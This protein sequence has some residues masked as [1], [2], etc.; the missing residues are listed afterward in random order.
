MNILHITPAMDPKM[1]GVCQ[2]VRTMIVGLHEFG[3]DNEVTSL[4]S[5]AA[6]F[7]N[8]DS[9]LIHP[10]GPATGPWL[11]S[12]T[13]YKWLISNMTRFDIV[14]VHGLWSYY[15]Y[16][17]IKAFQHIKARIAVSYK[18]EDS[19]PKLFVM[20]HGMLD[21]YFQKAKGR[22]IKSFRNWIYWKLLEKLL[23]NESNG[24]L[25]TC[26]E[27]RRLARKS[28]KPYYPR[29]ELVVGLGVEEPPA[30]TTD[31]H[32]A[33]LEKCPEAASSK[34]ILFLGRIDEKKGVDILITAYSKLKSALIPLPHLVI[35]GPGLSSAYGQSIT[36]LASQ[37]GHNENTITFLDML[38]GDAKW[39]AF[40]GCEA[41]VLPS[42]Q[43]NFGIA[44]VE[45]LA[46]SKPVLITK[47]VNIW[48]EIISSGG[49]LAAADTIEGIQHIIEAWHDRSDNQK[50]L[51]SEAA[52]NTYKDLFSVKGATVNLLNALK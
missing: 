1:G 18:H 8:K 17:A 4:D 30:Y 13:L 21:P 45:A 40:Y 32:N 6:P 31:M 5:P 38:T 41:F 15:G 16:A 34:F 35:A 25:F 52:Y 36:R 11:Y 26:I 43:E 29:L 9:F 39:G 19:E 48:Q 23:V 50:R 22:R 7:L 20:P 27:E 49:G 42:H 37:L 44:V 51:M 10:H 47:Q 3:V 24:L 2:A 14:I 33:F 28:L 12:R 46:C